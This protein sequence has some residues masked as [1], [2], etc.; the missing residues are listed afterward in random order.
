M[1]TATRAVAFLTIT[2]S[3]FVDKKQVVRI[4]V[5]EIFIFEPF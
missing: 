4:T 1:N 3:N 2:K 5:G